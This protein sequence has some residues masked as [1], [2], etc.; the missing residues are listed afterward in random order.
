MVQPGA[1]PAL[2]TARVGHRFGAR[3]VLADVSLTVPRGRFVA[4]L[5][6]NGAG[7]TTFFSIL[8]RLYHNRAG[9]VRIFG[10][11]LQRASSLALA[12]LGVVFQSR[13]LDP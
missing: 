4:L 3:Q 6:P 1:E 2:E 13:T 10:H 5:G 9:S 8:T 11:D 12:E 7:K